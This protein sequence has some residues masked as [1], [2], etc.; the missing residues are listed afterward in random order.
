MVWVDNAGSVAIWQ[1]G[2]STRCRLSSTIV[3]SIHAIAAAVGCTVNIQKITRCSNA[4]AAAAD[5][6][7]KGQ[8][9]AAR[10]F[11]QL[12]T[13]PARIPPALVRWINEPT[14]TDDL[15]HLVLRELAADS[16]ILNYSI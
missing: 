3:T 5:S 4:E 15:A 10:G 11:V 9:A 13:E 14:P 7:S 12:D 16:P 1:K 8:F 2:Y 6:L